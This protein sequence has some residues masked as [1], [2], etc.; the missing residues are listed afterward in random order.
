MPEP[1]TLI[2]DGMVEFLRGPVAIMFGAADV[3][4]VADA[5]RV[6]GVVVIQGR[7]LRVLIPA[8]A[9]TMLAN[10]TVG[11]RAAVLA[12]DIIDWR[13]LQWKGRVLAADEERTPGDLAAVHRYLDHF[14]E[15]APRVG[16]PSDLARRLFTLDVR[17]VVVE[18]D[19]VFDQTPGK[20]AGRCIGGLA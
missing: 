14:C 12:T 15:M 20:G 18:V 5:V 3:M 6:S 7:R 16:V 1:P 17:P 19:A 13:S 11:A 8:G 10:A 4:G 9:R 2:D